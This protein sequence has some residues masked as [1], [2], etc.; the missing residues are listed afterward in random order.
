MGAQA[1][2][3]ARE[4]LR[5]CELIRVIRLWQMESDEKT[6]HAS[7]LSTAFNVAFISSIERSLAHLPDA[8][9]CP[10]RVFTELS[11]KMCGPEEFPVYLWPGSKLTL[12]VAGLE[13]WGWR[14]QCA[15]PIFF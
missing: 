12:G 10:K 3:R 5:P 6:A 8:R 2:G 15:S 1:M 7:R 13:G 4:A 9:Q 11:R 14:L